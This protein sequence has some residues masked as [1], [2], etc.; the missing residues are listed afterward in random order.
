[1]ALIIHELGLADKEIENFLLEPT[2][3]RGHGQTLEIKGS[4]VLG[5]KSILGRFSLFWPDSDQ[6]TA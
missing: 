6:K 5:L 1:M 4:I 2:I 3:C